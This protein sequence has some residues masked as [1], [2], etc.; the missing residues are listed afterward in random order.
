[1][2]WQHVRPLLQAFQLQPCLLLSRSISPLL[3]TSALCPSCVRPHC[4]LLALCLLQ[5]V[6]MQLALLLRLWL[7][8]VVVLLLHLLF[9]RPVR[10]SA[11]SLVCLLVLMLVLL[12][13]SHLPSPSPTSIRAQKLPC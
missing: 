10:P 12:A 3:Q 1:M 2:G 11:L 4:H 8:P 9:G 13:A 5:P 6:C 7:Q